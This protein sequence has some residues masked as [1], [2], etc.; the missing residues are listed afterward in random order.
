M[1]HAFLI[2]AHNEPYILNILLKQIQHPDVSIYV[3]CDR[4]SNCSSEIEAITKLWGGYFL[5]DRIA[6]HWGTS[7]QIQCELKLFKSAYSNGYDYYHL[8][9][10][11]DLLIRPISEFL[12]FIEANAG[13]EFFSV[14]NDCQNKAD[15]IN[16]VNYY[17]FFLKSY[18]GTSCVSLISRFLCKA[19]IKLQKFIGLQRRINDNFEIYKGHNWMSLTKEAIGYILNQEDWILQ[20]FKFTFCSDEIYK[21]TLLMNSSFSYMRYVPRDIHQSSNLRQI[22]WVRGY[23]Y[24]WKICDKQEL[25]NSCNFIARKFSTTV[26]IHIIDWIST[27]I[28]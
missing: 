2:I 3:H 15:A 23:P 10:G 6:V 13:R 28:N 26:D 16:K 27:E 20:R 7:A 24:I 21:Q 4:K 19:F 12:Q 5:N 25:S 11:V 22:D 14:D 1:K 9:S 18:R 17:Y 8:V